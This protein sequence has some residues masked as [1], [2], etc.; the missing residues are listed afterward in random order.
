MRGKNSGD[1]TIVY[2]QRPLELLMT[3]TNYYKVLKI[4]VDEARSIVI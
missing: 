1:T 3:A 4:L 2:L